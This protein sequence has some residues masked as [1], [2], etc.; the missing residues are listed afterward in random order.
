MSVI[1]GVAKNQKGV[2]REWEKVKAGFAMAGLGLQAEFDRVKNVFRRKARF[3]GE[4]TGT[5]F[6]EWDNHDDKR[7]F[8]AAAPKMK[9]G[10]PG[11][12][13]IL[14]RHRSSSVVPRAPADLASRR[15]RWRAGRL[16]GPRHVDVEFPFSRCFIRAG[17]P[18]S[19]I[20]TIYVG[21]PSA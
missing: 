2:D 7:A 10:V 1:I 14:D 12:E 8:D 11:S 3:T 6:V 13:I 19:F 18:A 21:L 4:F 16:A 20:A 9:R 15:A 17:L 5:L